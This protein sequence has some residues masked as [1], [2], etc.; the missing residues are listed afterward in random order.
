MQT[1]ESTFADFKEA[2]MH[3]NQ[4]TKE[5]YQ[6][7]KKFVDTVEPEINQC[8]KKI[9]VYKSGPPYSYESVF[10]YMNHFDDFTLSA[11]RLFTEAKKVLEQS[12]NCMQRVT[13]VKNGTGETAAD[14]PEEDVLLSNEIS[15]L[16]KQL[17]TLPL[18]TL[19]LQKEMKKLESNWK[20]TRENT[21]L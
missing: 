7:A 14:K 17:K 4:V 10:S 13:S 2:C 19:D 21:R 11:N 6:S 20:K 16:F 8:V 5:L 18:R 12:E 3:A 15:E 9:S 1:S